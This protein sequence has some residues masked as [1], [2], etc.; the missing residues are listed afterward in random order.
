M[1]VLW[2][3]YS[4]YLLLSRLPFGM[5]WL[6]G[7]FFMFTSAINTGW[8]LQGLEELP[9]Q[10]R[11]MCL[12]S[13]V[14]AAA[15][16]SF[17]RPGMPAGSDIAVLAVSNVVGLCLTWRY[18]RRRTSASIFG[19]FDYSEV[20]ALLY[21]SR[22]AFAVV[23]TVFAYVQLDMILLAR[24]ASFE[25]AGVYRS[26]NFSD[27]SAIFFDSHLRN[28]ADPRFVVWLKQNPQQIW[29]RQK[30]IGLLY[31]CVGSVVAG[32]MFAIGPRLVNLLFGPRFSASTW[33]FL[34]LFVSKIELLISD[35]FAWGI[36]ASGRDK[37]FVIASF[38]GAVFSLCGNVYFIPRYGAIA[39][40]LVNFVSQGIILSIAGYFCWRR[41][42]RVSVPEASRAKEEQFG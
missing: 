40:A 19:R 24:F 2:V 7:A 25:Q 3:F 11:V 13:F 1:F 42:G 5:A 33:P 6:M 18:V 21:E 20:K 30:K 4:I 28:V 23:C 27:C 12:T 29:H 39:A 34:I 16:V 10:N 14:A 41:Y 17:F 26:C 31:L 8:I 37:L 36:M 9:V 32:A 22:W 38:T 35:V 15:Y